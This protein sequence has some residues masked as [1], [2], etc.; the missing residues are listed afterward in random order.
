MHILKIGTANPYLISLSFK[1]SIIFTDA[2]SVI[3]A[4]SFLH[5][6]FSLVYC[7]NSL[8]WGQCVQSHRV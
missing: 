3:S 5:L 7:S 2:K 6:R 1:L 4:F 8:L